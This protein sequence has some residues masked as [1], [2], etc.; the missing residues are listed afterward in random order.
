MQWI[1]AVQLEIVAQIWKFN[2][3]RHG[4]M[5]DIVKS[6]SVAYGKFAQKCSKK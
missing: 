1:T 2:V 5:A 3:C 6:L 4:C